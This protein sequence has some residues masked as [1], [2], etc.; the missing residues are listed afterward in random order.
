[1]Q[2]V[3]NTSPISN[4]A[5]IGRLQILQRQFGIIHV[6]TAVWSELGRLERPSGKQAI[7]Q[8]YAEGW[9]RVC[10]L[11]DRSLSKVINA[12]LDAGESEAIA[13]AVESRADLLVMDESAGRAMAR[14]LNLKMVGTLGL[15]LKEKQ[16]GGIPSIR[17]V[18][19]QLI[20]EA[21]FFVSASVRQTFL[22]AAGEAAHGASD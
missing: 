9:L 5:V 19:D 8:A 1:M 18:M 3:C 4:L 15:L 17:E 14:T 20:M 12:S 6:P 7:H 10:Q 13:L 21:G 2:V 16:A 22:A 11:T